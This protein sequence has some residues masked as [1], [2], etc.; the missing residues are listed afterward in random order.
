MCPIHMSSG[1]RMVALSTARVLTSTLITRARR[2]ECGTRR[3]F[4]SYHLWPV[5][6]LLIALYP[7]RPRLWSF[8]RHHRS[9]R[10]LRHQPPSR[11]GLIRLCSRVLR[12]VHSQLQV[13]HSR[14]EIIRL[15]PQPDVRPL[16][17]ARLP[18][19]GWHY[20]SLQMTRRF[21]RWLLGFLEPLAPAAVIGSVNLTSLLIGPPSKYFLLP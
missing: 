3:R 9:G 12:F 7:V 6:L 17:M 8:H 14:L 13:V 18:R 19:L 1:W 4:Q 21:L 20:R 15:Q 16:M 11:H 2:L 5:F 10:P